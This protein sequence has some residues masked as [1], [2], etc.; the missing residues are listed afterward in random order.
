MLISNL[1]KSIIVMNSLD[2]RFSKNIFEAVQKTR[3]TCFIGSKTTQLR[4]VVLDRLGVCGNRD[5]HVMDSCLPLSGGDVFSDGVLEELGVTVVLLGRMLEFDC[6]G[7]RMA[8]IGKGGTLLK[9][10]LGNLT[11]SGLVG[12]HIIYCSFF[13]V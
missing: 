8:S 13:F 3:S 9:T 7:K 2:A 1:H 12:S 5:L 11:S 10:L 4:L 6:P